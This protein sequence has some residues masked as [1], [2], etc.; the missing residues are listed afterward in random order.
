VGETELDPSLLGL[1]VVADCVGCD[2]EAPDED[3]PDVEGLSASN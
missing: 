3:P 1:L 2:V